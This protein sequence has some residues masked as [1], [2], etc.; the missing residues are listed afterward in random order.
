VCRDL[1]P[2]FIHFFSSK[3]GGFGCLVR[4]LPPPLFAVHSRFSNGSVEG[5]CI[6]YYGWRPL[7]LPLT[8]LPSLLYDCQQFFLFLGFVLLAGFAGFFFLIVRLLFLWPPRKAKSPSTEVVKPAGFVFFHGDK[9]F[10]HP[11][12][13]LG[14]AVLLFFTTRPPLCVCVNFSEYRLLPLSLSLRF[15]SLL[16]FA[17]VLKAFNPFFSTHEFMGRGFRFR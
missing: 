9:T 11:P 4:G 13:P 1:N 2:L 12:W 10:C 14:M 7:L 6:Q 8:V 3:F 5:R 17:P 15:P 16:S